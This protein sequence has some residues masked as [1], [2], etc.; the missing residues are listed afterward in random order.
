MKR[1]LALLAST[2]A[3]ASCGGGSEPA[4]VP[5]GFTQLDGPTY[6]F[7]HPTGWQG[8]ETENVLGAQGPKGTGGLEPQAG[9]S[10]GHSPA[11]LDLVMDAFLAEQKS[12]RGNWKIV[13][14]EPVEVDGAVEARLTDARYDQVTGN[15]TTPVRVVDVHAITEDGMLYDFFVRAPV[16]DFDGARLDEVLDTFRLK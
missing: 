8:L 12:R 2:A 14:D 16:A 11:S 1:S 15:M 3:I 10:S 4:A 9:V 7:A 5:Q 6:T 13:R